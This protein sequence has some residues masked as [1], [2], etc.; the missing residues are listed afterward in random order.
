MTNEMLVL[1]DECFL[2]ECGS[3]SVHS[4]SQWELSH[5]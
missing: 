4:A 1:V 3:G 2:K 5:V